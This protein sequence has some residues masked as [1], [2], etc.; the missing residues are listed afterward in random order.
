MTN[1]IID[2]HIHVWDLEKAE[3]TWLKGD[4]SIL[5]KAYS[6]KQLTPQIKEAGVTAGVLI[7]AANNFEDTDLMMQVAAETEWI[8]GVVGWLPLL[9]PEATEKALAEKF[10][11]N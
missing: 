4:T 3:Y 5:N 8:K 9:D 7:Q 11:D 2:T 1:S 10:R 6:I